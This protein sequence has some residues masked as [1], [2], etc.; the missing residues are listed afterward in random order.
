MK[1]LV[2][3]LIV[4]GPVM[5]MNPDHCIFDPGGVAVRGNGIIDVGLASELSRRYRGRKVINA[6]GKLTMPGLIDTY[7]HAGHGLIKAIHDVRR[8][9]PAPDV[10]FHGTT[11]DW[12]YAEALLTAVE[13]IRFGVTCGVTTIGA[14]PARTDDAL[15]AFQ[16]AAA[17]SESGLRAMIGVGPPILFASQPYTATRWHQGESVTKTYTYEDTME[18]TRRVIEEC[19]RPES[20]MLQVFLAMP[21]LLGQHIPG[22]GRHES[23]PVF[24]ESDIPLIIAKAEEARQLAD[25]YSVMIQTSIRTDIIERALQT[26]GRAKILELLGP[27]VCVVHGNGFQA[28]AIEILAETNTKVATAPSAPPNLLY[29]LCPVPPLIAAGVDVAI[30]TDGNAPYFSM[31]L[32]KDLWRSLY[33]NWM[34]FGQESYPAGKALRMVTIDAARVIGMQDRIGSLEPGKLADI[35]MIDL[36]RPHLIPNAHLPQLVAYYVNG[37]DVDT[38]LVDGKILMQNRC[39]TEI[40]EESVMEMARVEAQ[41]AFERVDI[42]RFF[43]MSNDYWYGT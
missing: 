41:L 43:Q 17:V 19:H 5:T 32:F 39:L 8:G 27:D 6:F 38:V 34:E 14:T 35:I 37:H 36:N 12:W 16:N 42:D 4:G 31:D 13:R 15:F 20:G 28:S 33:L 10:Y 9:W 25:D 2:D 26:M 11:G 40:D 7:S 30:S 3:T 18:Q 24:P 23:V 29:G 22:E 1:A 21:H